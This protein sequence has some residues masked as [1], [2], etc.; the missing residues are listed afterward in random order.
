MAFRQTTF[1]PTQSQQYRVT[2]TNNMG[3]KGG[4]LNMPAMEE[5]LAREMARMKME[6]EKQ[7]RVVEKM[8]AES[9]E[10]KALQAK[11]KAAYLNKDRAS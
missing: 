1:N 3:A 7:A 8:C 10:L 6:K 5:Q 2:G 11:I 9:E 4:P